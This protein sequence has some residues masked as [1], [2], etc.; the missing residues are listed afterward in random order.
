MIIVKCRV[1][2][3]SSLMESMTEYILKEYCKLF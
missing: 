2:E 3:D 1:G